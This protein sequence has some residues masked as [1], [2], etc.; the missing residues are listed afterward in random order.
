MIPATS[1]TGYSNQLAFLNP[2]DS[3]VIMLQNPMSSEL[4]LTM[5]VAGKAVKVTLPADSFTTV[6]LPQSLYA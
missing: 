5:Q 4:K 6:H 2:D 3:V 1:W